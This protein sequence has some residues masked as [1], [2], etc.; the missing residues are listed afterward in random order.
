MKNKPGSMIWLIAGVFLLVMGLYFLINPYATLASIAWMFGL[1][2]L[3]S[4]AAD[5]VLCAARQWVYG[6]S[7]WFFADGVID[8]IIGI[9]F[10]CNNWLAAELLPY[11]LAAWAIASG[12]I[13]CVGAL[14]YRGFGMPFWGAQFAVGLI[15]LVFGLVTLFRPAVAAVAVAAIVAIVLIAQG[16]MAIMRGLFSSFPKH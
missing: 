8:L 13:K 15:V 11:L 3:V 5:L 16:L 2:M 14:V 10:L 7:K 9:V 1:T 6:S 4:G 12:V